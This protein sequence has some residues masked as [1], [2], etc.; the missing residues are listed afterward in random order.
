M[1]IDQL[2]NESDIAG[3]LIASKNPS[4]AKSRKMIP[5]MWKHDRSIPHKVVASLGP[6]PTPDDILRAWSDLMDATLSLTNY[7]DLSSDGNFDM[8]LAK[9]YADGAAEYEDISGEAGDA[10][11]SWKALSLRRLL[12]P[13]DQDLNRFK[14]IHALQRV[15]RKGKYQTALRKIRD[16]AEIEKHKR[17]KLELVLIDDDRFYVTIPFNYGA[18]YTFN[19]AGG[20]TAN[21]C[22]GSSSGVGW[23]RRYGTDG[24]ILDVADKQNLDNKN[25]KW[26]LHAETNQLVNADQDERYNH[27]NNDINFSK[28]FPGLMRRIC[29]SIEAHGDQIREM[30]AVMMKSLQSGSPGYDI[31][32]EV[33]DIKRAFP[34]SYAS[35]EEQVQEPNQQQQG[36][37][38]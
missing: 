16:A 33:N 12:D 30:S 11:G 37:R 23:F 20:Y 24:I 18:C 9:C 35:G 5:V 1:K 34:I 26:Q 19:N 2:F 6:K 4:D 38:I 36:L 22:T 32:K 21:F 28:L 10:L 25:G 17:E 27:R 7:G 31:P 13:Q 8:W 3:K 14:S 15:M 29:A